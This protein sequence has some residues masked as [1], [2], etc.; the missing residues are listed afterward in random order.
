MTQDSFEKPWHGLESE[1]TPAL[2]LANTLDWRLRKEPI[3]LLKDYSD[4]VRWG[5]SVGALEPSEARA[6]RKWG[7]EHPK[8]AAR[9]L[10]EAASLREAIAAI[11]TSL[12][13]GRAP[14]PAPSHRPPLARRPNRRRRAGPV[15]RELPA[16]SPQPT[17]AC[18]AEGSRRRP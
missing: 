9:V 7:E 10:V 5:R 16:R 18:R 1:R 11:A 15:P 8:A 12:V 6:L 4:L 14:Q 13:K 2:A 17:P 3:E